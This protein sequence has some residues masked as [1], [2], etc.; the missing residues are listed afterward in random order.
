M[1]P[2][3][4]SEVEAAQQNVVKVVRRLEQTGKIIVSHG[5]GG[6]VLV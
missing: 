1:G 3:R 4:L 2:A 5:G 6:D